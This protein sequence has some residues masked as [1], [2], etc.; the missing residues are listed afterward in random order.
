MKREGLP[1]LPIGVDALERVGKF[2]AEEI[3]GLMHVAHRPDVGAL[4]R[5]ATDSVVLEV[6]QRID[7]VDVA[8]QP[9]VKPGQ[10]GVEVVQARVAHHQQRWSRQ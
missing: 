4:P 6:R 2:A 8:A 3:G 7:R 1:E 9:A 10:I 5:V